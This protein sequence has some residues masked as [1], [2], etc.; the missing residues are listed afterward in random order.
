MMNQ[1]CFT[2]GTS[3]GSSRRTPT[4][5]GPVHVSS[6][7]TNAAAASADDDDDDD[8]GGGAEEQKAGLEPR[9]TT[10]C[11]GGGGSTADAG[12]GFDHA[13]FADDGFE[14]EEILARERQER[15]R[16]VGFS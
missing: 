11:G 14:I 9:S 10:G 3:T 12:A 15:Q 7:S 2:L 4:S 5:L 6:A 13:S 8:G 1:P 16:C